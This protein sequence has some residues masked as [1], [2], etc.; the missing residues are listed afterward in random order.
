MRTS[1]NTLVCHLLRPRASARHPQLIPILAAGA[2]ILA[3]ALGARHA[4]G[5]F[6]QPMTAAHGWS[7]EVFALGMAAQ[8]LVWGLA[9]PVTGLIADRFGAKRVI[10]AGSALYAAGLA[11]MAVSHTPTQFVWGAGVLVGLGLSGTTF[12]V[13]LGAVSRAVA[14]S[15]RT[16]AMGITSA[17]GSFGQFIVL[18]GTMALLETGGVSSAL[19]V[20]AAVIAATALLS[21]GVPAPRAQRSNAPRVSWRVALRAALRH[22]AFWLLAA[23]FFVC[24]FQVSF[25][26]THL[27]SY[28]LDRGLPLGLGATVL[29]LIGLAN[30]AGAWLGG[31]AGERFSKPA[32]LAAIYAGRAIVMAVFIALPLSPVSACVFALVLGLLWMS[33]VPLTNGTIASLFGVENISLL[34]GVVFLFHQLGASMGGWLGGLLYDRTGDYDFMWV[35]AIAAGVLA[36]LIYVSMH[37][38]ERR[39]PEYAARRYPNVPAPARGR[40]WV[41]AS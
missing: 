40:T 39:N 21:R 34:G 15:Q 29:A 33:T 13:I 5:L 31:V 3:L 36:A 7:R 20:L 12:A 17:I 23:G 35:L 1:A 11:V 32:V 16:V 24:G 30:V 27:P 14:P 38:P 28:L 6:L 10:V 4:F 2:A 19:L 8:N 22:R 41:P 25:I 37:E 26:T 9:Q 18:P